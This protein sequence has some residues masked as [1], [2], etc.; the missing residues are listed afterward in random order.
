MALISFEQVVAEIEVDQDDLK[1]WIERSWVLPVNQEGA[2]FFDDADLARARL[3]AELHSD[4]E[5][6][7]EAMP[8][9]LRLLDQ[10][11]TLRK[12]LEDLNQAIKA[13]P[14]DARDQL[15]AELATI[16]G[17]PVESDAS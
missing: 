14:Q 1:V 4:L 17:R 7:D 15:R 10:V 5:V 9:V 8:V 2:Y 3:I 16:T 11:Y 6:N 12:A 13:L